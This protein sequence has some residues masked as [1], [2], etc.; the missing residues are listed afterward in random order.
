MAAV[1]V[2]VSNHPTEAARARPTLPHPARRPPL[3]DLLRPTHQP[4]ESI[5]RRTLLRAGTLGLAGL[6]LPDLFRASTAQASPPP[7][8][9]ISVI[10][11][12]L[13]GGP[14]QLDTWDPKPDAPDN[15]RGPFQ[16]IAT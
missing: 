13:S 14:S 12:F 11:L 10:L 9:D 1:S 8:S 4:G 16:T 5:S 15:I 2:L 7:R 3:L 6:S